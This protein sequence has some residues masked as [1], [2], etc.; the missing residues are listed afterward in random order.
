MPFASGYGGTLGSDLG[1][2]RLSPAMDREGAFQETSVASSFRREQCPERRSF[3]ARG[4]P[5]P[6]AC[7]IL[8][9][10]L[11]TSL[12]DLLTPQGMFVK[13]IQAETGARV[14]IKGLGSGFMEA[15]T[16]REAEEPMHINIA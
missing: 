2:S 11:S 5:V 9:P 8:G 1:V 6:S 14:Q 4:G 7:R 10:E 13:Y 12:D 3:Q 15:D 16:G